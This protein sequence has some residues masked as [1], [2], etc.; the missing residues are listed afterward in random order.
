MK[1]RKRLRLEKRKKIRSRIKLSVL[2]LTFLISI[3]MS[4]SWLSSKLNIKLLFPNILESMNHHN[5]KEKSKNVATSLLS[6]FSPRNATSFLGEN[7][8]TFLT[9]VDP[10]DGISLEDASKLSDYVEENTKP[11]STSPTVYIYNTHQREQYN[12]ENLEPYNITPNVMMASYMLQE[13]LKGYSIS[14]VVEDVDVTNILTKREL[15][16]AASYQVT[17]ELMTS[18]K[19]KYPSLEFFID[20]H[21][22]SVHKKVSTITINN[23]S[24]AKVMFL[25][26]LENENY[27]ENL[28]FITKINDSLEKNYPGISR[29]IW[30]KGGKGVNGI[31]N[32]DFNSHTIL[33][34]VGGEENTIEEVYH[35][36]TAIANVLAPLMKEGN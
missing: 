22:D 17:K 29:G 33:I 30:K 32:Q 10:D 14:S 28:A 11:P 34:E 23:E 1:R 21:R 8:H 16:Y 3:T 26:G 13:S 4:S 36:I 24:Y 15:N 25:V 2:I 7:N 12:M 19:E 31:Y 9:E 20:L 27:E 35:T 6:F 18:A 5:E